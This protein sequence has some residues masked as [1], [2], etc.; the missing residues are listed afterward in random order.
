MRTPAAGGPSSIVA[1]IAPWKSA[2]AWLMTRSSSPRSSG[3]S[4]FWAV[5]YGAASAPSSAA[6]TIRAGNERWPVQCSTGTRSISGARTRSAI[7]IER[8][9]PNRWTKLPAGSPAAARPSKLGDDHERHLA[10]RARRRE[11]EPRQREPGH[12][13]AGGRDHLGDEQRAQRAVLEDLRPAH[14]KFS[15][16]IC[17][18]GEASRKKTPRRQPM[19][20]IHKVGRRPIAVPSTPPSSAPNGRVP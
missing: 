4:T 13:R 17:G 6:S 9:A 12:L 14:A 1:R 11:D 16:R 18:I 20:P 3:T 8:R 10:R 15:S 2:F 5:K 7:N 19:T